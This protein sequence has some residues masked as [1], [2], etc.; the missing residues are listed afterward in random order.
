MSLI[1]AFVFSLIL[2]ALL[3]GCSEDKSPKVLVE[4]SQITD[5]MAPKY[6]ASL[7]EGIDFKKPGYPSFLAEVSGVSGKEDFGRWS[8]GAVARFRF[9][10]LL[11][12]KF[13]VLITAGAFGPNLG[14]PVIIRVGKAEK[15]FVV[16][17]AEPVEYSVNFE[18]INGVDT[19]EVVSQKPTRPKDIDPKNDDSRLLGVAL[20]QLRI[21]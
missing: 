16:K 14:K 20:V 10:Q 2:F 3:P 4:G 11:P 7:A 13:A 17:T 6:E 12:S 19:I 1:K 15:E 21:Q 18:G 8:D 9:K 5:Q